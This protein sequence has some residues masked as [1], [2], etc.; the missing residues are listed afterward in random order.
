M[1]VRFFVLFVFLCVCVCFLRSGLCYCC[2][3]CWVFGLLE[4]GAVRYCAHYT[5]DMLCFV[6]FCF[7][8]FD[9]SSCRSLLLGFRRLLLL[10]CADFWGGLRSR[11]LL[12]LQMC[13]SCYLE[14]FTSETG[15]KHI[16]FATCLYLQHTF[17][18][19]P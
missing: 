12:V 9:V 6:L 7:V 11:I 1:V 19:L 15:G 2:S 16:F 5:C 18:V 14:V 4:A 13:S 3:Y 17:Q 10:S 8:S